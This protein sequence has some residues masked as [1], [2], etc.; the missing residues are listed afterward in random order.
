MNV[1]S[2]HEFY[3]DFCVLHRIFRA[4]KT[5]CA[6]T[7]PPTPESAI[8]IPATDPIKLLELS[9]RCRALSTQEPD[10]DASFADLQADMIC[11]D[12]D[13]FTTTE[14]LRAYAALH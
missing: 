7:S 5:C 1:A 4:W 12:S 11:E 10:F 9:R 6:S 2:K 3:R 8:T 14:I 13:A